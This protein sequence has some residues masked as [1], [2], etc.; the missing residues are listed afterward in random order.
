M[1]EK[2]LREVLPKEVVFVLRCRQK[3]TVD[4]WQ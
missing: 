4:E 3:N 1:Q 2:L